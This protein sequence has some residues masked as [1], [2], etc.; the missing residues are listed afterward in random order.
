MVF[1]R[2]AKR[3]CEKALNCHVQDTMGDSFS[4]VG[5]PSPGSIVKGPELHALLGRE[6]HCK[7][8]EPLVPCVW[9]DCFEVAARLLF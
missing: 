2:A 4:P 9:L 8:H 7:E 1:S 6:V 5:S 3:R